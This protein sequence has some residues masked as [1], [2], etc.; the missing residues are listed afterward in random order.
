MLFEAF[1]ALRPARL[2][3]CK[4]WCRMGGHGES[5]RLQNELRLAAVL[6]EDD[7]CEPVEDTISLIVRRNI[8]ENQNDAADDWSILR[9][10]GVAILQQRLR[11]RCAKRRRNLRKRR[12]KT[13]VASKTWTMSA[14][15]RG[16]PHRIATDRQSFRS[17]APS[18]EFH[19]GAFIAR[20]S[21]R[22]RWRGARRRFAFQNASPGV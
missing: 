4:V 13:Q 5:A 8:G 19:C 12:S 3:A 10:I 7:R 6:G 22:G 15:S 14:N 20:G 9:W 18:R 17:P 11:I 16:W 1:Q 2:H 21:P